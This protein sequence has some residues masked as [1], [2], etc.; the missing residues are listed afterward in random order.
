MNR[1]SSHDPQMPPTDADARVFDPERLAALH[2]LELLDSSAEEPFDRLTRLARRVL[3][4]P[5]VLLSLVDKDRQFFKSSV[6]LPDPWASSRQTPLSHS[7]CRH[8]VDSQ[9][10]LIVHDARLHPL[11][12]DN[13]AV[14]DLQVIAYAGFPLTTSDGHT[15]GAFCSIDSQPREWSPV[16]LDILRDIAAAAMTEIELRSANAQLANILAISEVERA[17]KEFLLHSMYHGVYGLDTGGR[18][19]F[20][21]AAAARVLGYEAAELIGRDM[22]AMIHS[23]RADGAPYP[24]RDGRVGRGEDD[25]YW[26]K[27]GSS[28][29]VEYVASPL[30]ADSEISGAVVTFWDIT[31]RKEMQRR[32]AVQHAVSGV[33]AQALDFQEAAPQLLREIGSALEWQ[34][35]SVWGVD[36]ATGVLRSVFIWSNPAIPTPN[37]EAATRTIAFAKGEGLPGRVWQAG[38]PMWSADVLQEQNFTRA[39]AAAQDDLHGAICFPIL[40]A[41]E[42]KGVIEFFSNRAYAPDQE[43]LRTVSTVGRQIGEFMARKTAENALEQSEARK[44][45]IFSAALDGIIMMDH[46]GRVLDWNS[47][48]EQIFGYSRADVIGRDLAEVIIPQPHRAAHRRG[49]ERYLSTGAGPMLDQRFEI[50]ARHAADREFPVELAITRVANTAQPVFVG[51]VRDITQR[52]QTEQNLYESERF[53]NNVVD[54]LSSEIAILD[55]SGRII[56][57][58]RLWRELAQRNGLDGDSA[59]GVGANYLDVCDRAAEGGSGAAAAVAAGIRAVIDGGRTLFDYEYACHSTEERRWFVARVTRFKGDGPVRIVIA[60]ENITKRKLAEIEQARYARY[61]QLLLDSTGEG[62]YGVDLQGRC[63]FINRAAAKALGLGADEAIGK[64]MHGLTHHHREDGSVYPENEC[65]IYDSFRTGDEYKIR[66]EVFWRSDGSCFPV[67]YSSNPLVEGD[68]VRG[69]VV[70]FSDVSQ[71][72]IAEREVKL[73]SL[74]ASQTDNAVVI[75]GRDRKIEWVNDGFTRITGYAADEVLGRGPGEILQGPGTDPATV[76]RIRRRLQEKSSFSEEILNYRKNGEPYWLSLNVTPVLDDAGEV[77][78][79][80][81]IE[82]DISERKTEELRRA[83]IAEVGLAITQSDHLQEM[84]QRCAAALLQKLEGAAVQ[85]WILEASSGQFHSRAA[86]GL[87]FPVSEHELRRIAAQREPYF[88]NSIE[89]IPRP[90]EVDRAPEGLVAFAGYPLLVAGKVIGIV[91]L[92]SRHPLAP[93]TKEALATAANGVALG[94]QRVQHQEALE[95]SKQAAEQANRA[96]SQFLA[97]MSHELRTPLNAI[98]MYSELLMEETGGT[99]FGKYLPDLEKIRGAGKH[100][101]SLISNVLDLSK[102]E[103]GK[104]DVF[105]EEFE[106]QAMVHEVAATMRPLVAQKSNQLQVACSRDVGWIYSDLTKVRQILFNLLSNASKF[107]SNGTVRLSVDKLVRNGS[108]WIQFAVQ[109]SGIGMTEE[110]RGKLFQAFTQADSSTTRKY[111]GTGLGLAISQRLCEML[112]GEIK[113]ESQPQQGAT[114][115]LLL[116]R[117]L[118]PEVRAASTVENRNLITSDGRQ[119]TVLVIDDDPQVLEVMSRLLHSEGYRSVTASGGEEGL[120]LARQVRPDL[121]IL[122]VMMPR[123]DG[124]TVLSNLKSDSQLAEIPVV[125]ISVLDESHFSYFLGASDYLIK[126]VQPERLFSILAKHRPRSTQCQVLVVDDDADTRRMLCDLVVRQGWD[127]VEAENGRQALQRIA[128]SRPDMVV[129]D[130]LM[131]D[132]DGFEFAGEL[133]RHERWRGIPIIVLS[134]KQLDTDERRQLT[135]NVRRV[136]Q[137]G[138]YSHNG[139]QQMLREQMFAVTGQQSALQKTLTNSEERG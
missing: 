134:A 27:D 83:L 119:G 117:S 102:I 10:P 114:F 89:N 135:G 99:E 112:Q 41:G 85:I 116:P 50:E 111:G 31:E 14:Q 133:Q 87:D 96:K 73:L 30:A 20:I 69:A 97:N 98:I 139:L 72:L 3:K 75:T 37:F 66:G 106:V 22:H 131:P 9:Q 8:V 6:G 80:I 107:T 101:L 104:M 124:W 90:D 103:A 108:E 29:P 4:T 100:L 46:R 2:R 91:T 39:P 12:K 18:C 49:L 95:A 82:S 118:G 61:N 11:V 68:A 26:R 7:F 16:E 54:A 24:R 48:A 23:R 32:M 17:Q 125:M 132:M 1:D 63:T 51:F 60:H 57:V 122:D 109:D 138:S 13:P 137:K 81:A 21:N 115:S 65:P 67:E 123:T 42:V 79:F 33:L 84:L 92:V 120:R 64:H 70:V 127:V 88:T 53:A 5:V 58:N 34:V 78:R 28:F 52:R 128:E 15:L 36:E 136:L 113:V 19:T 56:F 71:R 129:L 130:L 43:L 40:L 126:P 121:V 74:V 86:T 44:T 59:A 105:S 38:A 110:Q 47:A 55:S 93:A 35:G 94:I 45:A 76:E 25:V 77:E 62:I